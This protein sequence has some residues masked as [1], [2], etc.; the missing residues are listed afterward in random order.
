M[1]QM[2]RLKTKAHRRV[3]WFAV[4]N[5]PGLIEG[6][7]PTPA[8]EEEEEEE[9]DARTGSGGGGGGGGGGVEEA[10]GSVG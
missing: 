9:E 4:W 8:A 7:I 10:G 6:T 2:V 1:A 5:T 3:P